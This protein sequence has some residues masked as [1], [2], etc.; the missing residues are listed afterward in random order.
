MEKFRFKIFALILFLAHIQ[1]IFSID[2][3]DEYDVRDHYSCKSFNDIRNQKGCGGCWAFSTAEVISD[4][5]C[6]SSNGENQLIVS[7]MEI[8]T[9]C[10][11][12]NDDPIQAGCSGGDE[13]DAFNYWVD[14]GLPSETCKP[15]LFEEDEVPSDSIEKLEC[16]NSCEDGVEK[17]IKYQGYSHKQIKGEEEIKKEILTNGPVT[18]GYI[19]YEDFFN[20]WN[21][22]RYDSEKIY[23]NSV[24]NSDPGGHSVKIIGWGYSEKE[25]KKYWLCVNSWGKDEF[26]T[27]VFKF[28]RGINDCG[29]ESDINTGYV[30]DI[31]GSSSK[32]R[33]SIF[34][35]LFLFVF[36]L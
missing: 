29:I 26:H 36:S 10:K 20:Y 28:V 6:I 13:Y 32:Y 30:E 33:K 2:I 1:L 8:L 11:T 9:C 31:N 21:N 34:M 14:T 4:R 17:F 24:K 12:L 19:F 18:A 35:V 15:F 16:K 5:Y 7:E 27:G 23:Q 3:P 22:L 25:K